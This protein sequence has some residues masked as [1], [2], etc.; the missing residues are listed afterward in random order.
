MVENAFTSTGC[1]F[2]VDPSIGNFRVRTLEEK[3][4]KKGTLAEPGAT[5]FDLAELEERLGLPL[6][7]S[8]RALL[9]ASNGFGVFGEHV[10]KLLSAKEVDWYRRRNPDLARDR[11]S[12]LRAGNPNKPPYA[13]DPEWRVDIPLRSVEIAEDFDACELILYPKPTSL[14]SE[15]QV[16]LGITGGFIRYETLPDYVDY[17]TEEFERQVRG[18]SP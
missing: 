2:R 3:Y 14:G 1:L 18:G 17:T 10:G 7:P 5:E 13:H 15:W 12:W 4:V 9:Q 8:Y 16:W 11:E 6:C